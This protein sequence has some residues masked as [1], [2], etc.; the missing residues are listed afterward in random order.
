MSFC[1]SPYICVHTHTHRHI[2]G[3]VRIWLQNLCGLSFV[4]GLLTPCLLRPY[5]EDRKVTTYWT[6]VYKRKIR[7]LLF[8]MNMA[9]SPKNGNLPHLGF[10]S[11][12]FGFQY[13]Y[14]SFNT[15]G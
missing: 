1:L 5:H 8:A 3:A 2:P 15:A 9:A 12:L 7:I 13:N 4:L 14:R 10:F 6:K 11:H